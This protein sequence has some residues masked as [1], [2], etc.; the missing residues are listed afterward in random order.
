MHIQSRLSAHSF[1]TGDS[2]V[3][4][5]YEEAFSSILNETNDFALKVYVVDQFSII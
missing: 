4:M 3:K 1:L 5:L 2:Y